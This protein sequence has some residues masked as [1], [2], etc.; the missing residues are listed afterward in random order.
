MLSQEED[1]ELVE[2]NNWQRP[3]RDV[4]I[5]GIRK[6]QAVKCL[7]THYAHFL[8][9]RDNLIGLWTDELL[10]AAAAAAA[11][12]LLTAA[13]ATAVVTDRSSPPPN[14]TEGDGGIFTDMDR[15]TIDEGG[16]DGEKVGEEALDEEGGG[17]AEKAAAGSASSVQ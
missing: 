2:R 12:E 1:L 16:G 14:N 8:A 9:T 5:A 7:H 15:L 11:D 6:C 4:G 13:A 3:L 10:T 17:E